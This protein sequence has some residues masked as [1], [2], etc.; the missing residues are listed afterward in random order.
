MSLSSVKNRKA[1]ERCESRIKQWE[2]MSAADKKGRNKP[3]S[4]RK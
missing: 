2:S 3:G 1:L 4:R